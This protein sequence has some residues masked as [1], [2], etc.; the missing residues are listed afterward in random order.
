[1]AVPIYGINCVLAEDM[2]NWTRESTKAFEAL[3]DTSLPAPRLK[4]LGTNVITNVRPVACYIR[5]LNKAERNYFVHDL[6]SVTTP[7]L[8][9]DQSFFK[10]NPHPKRSSTVRQS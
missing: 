4:V 2:F 5:N 7:F 6:H 8:A 1:M 9:E 3:E 10:L